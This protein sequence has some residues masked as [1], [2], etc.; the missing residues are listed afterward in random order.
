MSTVV[1]SMKPQLT[2][3]HLCLGAAALDADAATPVVQLA[4]R[5][6]VRLTREGMLSFVACC[7]TEVPD[8]CMHAVVLHTASCCKLT[9][10]AVVKS[11]LWYCLSAVNALLGGLHA[12][13]DTRNK[14]H[15]LYV[16]LR[17]ASRWIPLIRA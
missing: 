1:L 12:A 5:T 16:R 13:D 15:V 3:F 9:G 11:L 14:Q 10:P 2:W 4:S 7:C 6:G 17:R 8:H